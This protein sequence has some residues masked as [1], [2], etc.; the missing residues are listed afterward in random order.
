MYG[1]ICTIKN[2]KKNPKHIAKH[3]KIKIGIK[4]VKKNS[5]I[6]QHSEGGVFV[7]TVKTKT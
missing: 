5:E 3:S 4:K 7:S 1:E 6:K 2:D